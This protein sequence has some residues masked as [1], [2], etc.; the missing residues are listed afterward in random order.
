MAAAQGLLVALLS[1]G[2]VNILLCC[3]CVLDMLL[4]QQLLSH[5]AKSRKSLLITW[6]NALIEC[7]LINSHVK[8]D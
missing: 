5:G 6:E 3:C 4:H 8:F 7:D 2:W 1:G